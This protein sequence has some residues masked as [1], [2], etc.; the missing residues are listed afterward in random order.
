M[1]IGDTEEEFT[2]TE[3]TT[4]IITTTKNPSSNKERDT[5]KELQNNT[6]TGRQLTPKEEAVIFF[7][8]DVENILLAFDFPDED[9]EA[10][11]I[12]EKLRAEILKFKSYWTEKNSTGT[13]T[14][15]QLEKTFEVKKRLSTWFG[16]ARDF[17]APTWKKPDRAG[18]N[19]NLF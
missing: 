5:K 3:N 1:K 15:W 11:K 8:T 6:E 9:E 2:T 10:K 18:E 13:K 4:T 12:K 7:D 14:R 19:H 16:K 17:S